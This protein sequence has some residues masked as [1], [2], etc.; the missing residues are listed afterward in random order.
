MEANII[1]LKGYSVMLL[2]NHTL[3]IDTRHDAPL[4]SKDFKTKLLKITSYILCLGPPPRGHKNY[5]QAGNISFTPE[6]P[7]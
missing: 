3:T 2:Y 5:R 6:C 1:P 4:L 7:F